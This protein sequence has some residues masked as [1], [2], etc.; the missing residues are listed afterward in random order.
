MSGDANISEKLNVLNSADLSVSRQELTKCCGSSSW[1][2]RM[3]EA[4][5]FQSAQSIIECADDIWFKLAPADWL[6]AFTHHPK[7]GDK[8]SLEAKFATTAHWAENEQKGVNNADETQLEDLAQLNDQYFE[9]FGYIFIVC[10][11]G[12]TAGEMLSLLK[13]R[14][15]NLPSEELKIAAKEQSKITKIRLEKLL[16]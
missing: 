7:I 3:L 11:T 1:V 12:K 9:K 16:S 5:P 10:A 4:R 8:A 2:N 13:E 15:P 6:E 14:L